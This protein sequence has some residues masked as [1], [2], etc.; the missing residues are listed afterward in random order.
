MIEDSPW[1]K[2]YDLLFKIL[3]EEN[4]RYWSRFTISI[5]INGGLIVVFSSLISSLQKSLDLGLGN[6]GVFVITISGIIFSVLWWKMTIYA[7][8]WANFYHE[9]IKAIEKENIVE[10]LRI[11]PDKK[12]IVRGSITLTALWYPTIFIVFWF[13]LF[14]ALI[15]AF[16]KMIAI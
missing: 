11:F 16:L 13:I 3:T 5:L 10:N 9:K 6:I 1:R 14:F 7:N 2:Q 15:L 8:S 12:G 4:H